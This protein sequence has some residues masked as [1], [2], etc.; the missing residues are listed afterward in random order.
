MLISGVGD[1]D[2]AIVRLYGLLLF[3]TQANNE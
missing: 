1:V 2:K 3:K